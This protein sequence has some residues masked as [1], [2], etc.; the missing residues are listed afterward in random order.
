MTIKTSSLPDS[1]PPHISAKA[2]EHPD[3]FN[4]FFGRKGGISD[5]VYRSLNCG[6]GSDDEPDNIARN[7]A[8]VA[9]ASGVSPENLISLY[10]VHSA[11]CITVTKIWPNDEQRP[12]ADA[13]VTD[14][15]G[16]ALGILTA[17]CAPVLFAGQKENGAPVIGAAHAG[18][19]GAISGVL[20]QTVTAMQNLGA[21]PETLSACVGPC[22]GK[23]SYEVSQDF[24]IP[25]LEE[26][27]ES[28]RFFH[29][30]R[31]EGHAMFDLPGYCA[32]RLA[33]TG[34]KKIEILDQDT[35]AREE[36]YF[37]YR[38][39]TLRKEKDYARQISVIAIQPKSE[40]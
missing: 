33:R 23:A 24:I 19:R 10:Q 12:K 20:E 22:I 30:A 6:L 8:L 5:D 9:K 38:R 25:F 1:N 21:Q 18:W 2:I 37:S 3:I 26:N 4:G 31:K 7:R 14:Q 34:L 17:D 15:T 28:E 35:C 32:W 39:A 36:D 27:D 11:Q 29:P 40:R 16:A 13:F